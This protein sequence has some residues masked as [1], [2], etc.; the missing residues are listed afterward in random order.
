M[1]PVPASS[2]KVQTS[3][4]K[5]M[6]MSK[7]DET[8][9]GAETADGKETA[10][11]PGLYKKCGDESAV[12]YSTLGP[13]GAAMFIEECIRRECTP[14]YDFAVCLRCATDRVGMPGA[15]D[16]ARLFFY[17]FAEAWVSVAQGAGNQALSSIDSAAALALS[18]V[19]LS[20]N[21]HGS[22]VGSRVVPKDRFIQGCRC[23]DDVCGVSDA[24]SG[25]LYDNLAV[26][27]LVGPS[28]ADRS[29]AQIETLDAQHIAKEGWLMTKQLGRDDAKWRRC[30]A[31]IYEHALA[32]FITPQ[33]VTFSEST[34]F[35]PSMAALGAMCLIC[36]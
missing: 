30:W 14:P 4:L 31:R 12:A 2:L 25:A 6:E 32:L 20:H 29:T 28:P 15:F 3:A 33:Q 21:L 34:F 22:G 35:S 13:S 27:P 23:L 19:M 17:H 16:Q 1:A 5:V 24:L 26:R 10:E 18:G 36:P 11:H 7:H 9:K 8:E